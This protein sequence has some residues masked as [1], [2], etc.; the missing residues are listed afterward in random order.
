VWLIRFVRIKTGSI[1]KTYRDVFG[2]IWKLPKNELCPVCG[3]PDNCG[4]CN[5]VRLTKADV[6]AL[7]SRIYRTQFGTMQRGKNQWDFAI[8]PT[9][10]KQ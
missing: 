10:K 5:H 9:S 2:R 7:G 6:V 8:K 4:D 1:M 3:Q